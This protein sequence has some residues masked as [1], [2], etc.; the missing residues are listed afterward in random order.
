MRRGVMTWVLGVSGVIGVV[1]AIGEAQAQAGWTAE[2]ERALLAS[3]RAQDAAAGDAFAE[4]SR[5]RER[6]DFAGAARA[7]ERAR[8]ALPTCADAWRRECGMLVALRRHDDAIARCERAV[9]LAPSVTNRTALASTLLESAQ[10]PNALER[11]V[12]AGTLLRQALAE[13]R[14]DPQALSVQCMFDAQTHN[15]DGLEM[16][17]AHLREQS[18]ASPSGWYFGAVAAGSR[19]RLDEATSLLASARERGLADETADRLARAI[20]DAKPW[21]ERWGRRIVVGLA[22]WLCGFLLLFGV[23]DVLS[24]MV[25]RATEGVRDASPGA[26]ERALRRTYGAVIALTCGYFFASVPLVFLCILAITAGI[27]LA[28]FSVGHVPVKAVALVLVF[29]LST[30]WAIGRGIWYGLIAPPPEG[31]PGERLRLDQHPRLAAMLAQ[32]AE[33]VGTRPVDTVFVTP[34]TDFAVFERGSFLARL[35]RRGERC[36]VLGVGLL[37]GFTLQGLRAVVAHE[38]GHF[39]NEDTA[40]GSLA[41]VVRRSNLLL[42]MN[43]AVHGVATPY[44]PA[45]WFVSGFHKVFLRVSQGASRMQEILADRRAVHA[46][47][48]A[49]FEQGLRHAIERAVRFEVLA[50]ATLDEVIARRAPL[51]NLYQREPERRPEP[52]ALDAAVRAAVERPASP[53]DSHP[54][55]TE[56]MERAWLLGVGV[57]RPD[58]ADA[59]A[60]SL[61]ADREA[62]ER[63][64]TALVRGSIAAKENVV[65]PEHEAPPPG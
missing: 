50:N 16:D 52:E 3:V 34:G 21:H 4:G 28:I 64:M 58:D 20:E 43:L 59:P 27:V 62:L 2:Q 5:L 45:W 1:C 49:A 55:P 61:F 37:D 35:R 31:D 12:A 40:N 24:G 65:L 22:A 30:L 32:V 7:F 11:Q 15:F 56:R 36:M 19:G 48:P 39:S 26:G 13:S 17:A 9:S 46:Y 23:G 8:T 60:W 54:S 18:P 51:S 42:A 6:G 29:G 25:L 63:Q 38:Y 41:L 57:V 47:G 44:N 14:D 33:R 53:Y 10:G